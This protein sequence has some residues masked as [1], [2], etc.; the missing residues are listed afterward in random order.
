MTKVYSYNS[1]NRISFVYYYCSTM[2]QPYRCPSMMYVYVIHYGDEIV[3]QQ[4][5]VDLHDD[6][7]YYYVNHD[8]FVSGLFDLLP[9]ML[10]TDYACLKREKNDKISQISMNIIR[11]KDTYE[12]LL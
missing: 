7:Y 1:S 2:N 4:I 3:D 9:S 10:R 8:Y 11:R 6:Y 5:H 12:V